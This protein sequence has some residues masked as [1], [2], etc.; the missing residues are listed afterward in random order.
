MFGGDLVVG[1]VH[2]DGGQQ[3]FH[4]WNRLPGGVESDLTHE[5]FRRG[6]IVAGARVVARPPGP[7][8]R[9]EEYL[10]LRERV[11]SR[12]GRLPEPAA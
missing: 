7:L 1:E 9:W 8:K 11:A 12:L 6:E 3:G 5:Q 4:W 2:V 10:L